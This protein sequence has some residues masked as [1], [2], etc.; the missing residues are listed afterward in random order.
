MFLDKFSFSLEHAIQLGPFGLSKFIAKW[1]VGGDYQVINQII[2]DFLT[3]NVGRIGYLKENNAIKKR[4]VEDIKRKLQKKK[5]QKF[6]TIKK[7]SNENLQ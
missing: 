2:T 3:L 4:L 1:C 6:G 7:K 5:Y